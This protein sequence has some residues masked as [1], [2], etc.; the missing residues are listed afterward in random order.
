V[1][2]EAAI[3]V[4]WTGDAAA[5]SALV[6]LQAA[7]AAPRIL[8]LVA[9]HRGLVAPWTQAG[10]DERQRRQ[11]HLDKPSVARAAGVPPDAAWFSSE[12]LP[13]LLG[14]VIQKDPFDIPEDKQARAKRPPMHSVRL[15]LN[16]ACANKEPSGFLFIF[17]AQPG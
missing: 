1:T 11:L 4:K 16:A 13:T 12:R 10:R 2:A 17:P 3:P 8:A 9:D 14:E 7:V 15:I 6:Q 5:A